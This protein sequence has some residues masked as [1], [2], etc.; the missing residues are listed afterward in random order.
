MPAQVLYHRATEI[1]FELY[2]ICND[3]FINYIF[4]DI[5][6]K[7]EMVC[8]ILLKRGFTDAYKPDC[9]DS[10]IQL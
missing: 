7:K 4:I 8:E 9:W 6:D 1:P 10:R 2:V 3:T 5:Y